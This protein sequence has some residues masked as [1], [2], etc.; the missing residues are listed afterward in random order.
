MNVAINGLGRIGKSVL[1]N[2]LKQKL[3]NINLINDL[4]PDI[5]NICYLINYDST[6]GKLSNKAVK[7]KNNLLKIGNREIKYFS[8]E[9]IDEIDLKNIDVLIDCTGRDWSTKSIKNLKK[10]LKHLIFTNIP[11]KTNFK[12]FLSDV[13]LEKLNKNDFVI[14]SGTCDGNAVLPILKILLKYFDIES[15]N[16]TTLHPWLSYQNLLDGPLK[17]ISDPKNMYSTY[18]LGRSSINNII[19]KT[20]SVV[21]V[22]SK[23]YPLIKKKITCLSYRVP[24]DIVSCAEL[25][26]TLKNKINL[27]QI[28]KELIKFEKNQSYNLLKNFNY[29][30]TSLD[31]KGSTYSS[32]VDHRWINV[33]SRQLRIVTWY[34]NEMGYASRVI[35]IL[36]KIYMIKYKKIK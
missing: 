4:N 14:S 17:S 20:T 29:P 35:D 23:I 7:I 36:K 1:L 26:I 16:I 12:Y 21:D 2:L 33:N 32:N 34:D 10:K 22:A 8:K 24:T 3:I 5:D 19:P 13:N 27:S 11:K 30:L 6:Y 25:N 15:G 28:K 9:N 31:L 18:V